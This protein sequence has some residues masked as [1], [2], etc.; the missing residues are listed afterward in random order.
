MSRA[1]ALVVPPRRRFSPSP[2]ALADRDARLR[3]S[4]ATGHQWAAI[5]VAGGFVLTLGGLAKVAYLAFTPIAAIV[6]LWLLVRRR[7]Y[8]YLA[9]TGWMW[10]LSPFMRRVIEWH[11]GYHASSLILIPPAIAGLLGLPFALAHRRRLD[12][13]IAFVFGLTLFVFCYGAL[14]GVVRN[15]AYATALDVLAIF[16]PFG[17]GL[18][19]L[20]V[21]EDTARLRKTVVELAA[22]GAIIIGAYGVIQFFLLPEWDKQWMLDSG[23]TTTGRPRPGQV[24]VFSTL[25]DA[26]PYAEV[27]VP[28]MIVALLDRRWIMRALVWI[29]GLPGAALSLVR[30][31]WLGLGAAALGL[32]NNGRL[33]ARTLVTVLG[34]G[35][36]VLAIVGG[37][38][39]QTLY[40]RIDKSVSSGSQDTSLQ[41]RLNFQSQIA[42]PTLADPVGKG[43]GATGTA[44]KLG[45][46]SETDPRYRSVDSGIF[47][48]ATAFGSVLGFLLIGA[49]LVATFAAWWRAQLGHPDVAYY[50]AGLTV[51]MVGMI[52]VD[53]LKNAPGFVFWLLLAL[54]ARAVGPVVKRVPRQRPTLARH[55]VQLPRRTARLPQQQEPARI[56]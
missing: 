24:R 52:F 45:G 14:I 1:N 25:N 12:R 18:Y 33:K 27:L 55:Q 4:A 43:M 42:G 51:L 39:A 23:V 37:T 36:L 28:L 6:T 13:T 11:A 30:T 31:A 32:L 48:N 3:G 40:N 26:T 7:S 2:E 20:T 10:L 41:A 54:S 22:W 46:A 19:A 29:C 21:P 44:L 35:L 47:E 8:S 50:A 38:A 34:G 56:T 16:G 5:M 17:A 49:L 15:G 53:N 9:F